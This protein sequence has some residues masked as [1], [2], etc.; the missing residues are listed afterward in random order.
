MPEVLSK[1][2][3]KGISAKAQKL[4]SPQ[5]HA[6][7]RWPRFYLAV[8]I[9]R[10]RSAPHYDISLLRNRAPDVSEP[11]IPLHADCSPLHRLIAAEPSCAVANSALDQ[12]RG[13]QSDGIVRAV[14]AKNG[15]AKA[16]A[17]I[18]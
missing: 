16:T 3:G 17:R 9:E 15:P 8:L 2:D 10:L 11:V 7:G 4:K 14:C 1:T 13:S 5:P 6:P 18:I 12:R